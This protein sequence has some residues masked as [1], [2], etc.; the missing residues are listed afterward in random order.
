MSA[1]LEFAPASRTIRSVAKPFRNGVQGRYA[2]Q[3]ATKQGRAFLTAHPEAQVAHVLGA[4]I[5]LLADKLAD[6]STPERERRRIAIRVIR[7][8]RAIEGADGDLASQ[9]R[10]LVVALNTGKQA[11]A[12]LA[13]AGLICARMSLNIDFDPRLVNT[14]DDATIS[15]AIGA[16]SKRTKSRSHD[17]PAINALAVALGC[18]AD[19][20]DTLRKKLIAIVA[21]TKR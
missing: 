8:R 18:G 17:W 16:W 12:N 15:A 5:L 9:R 4:H 21:S 19:D 6:E 11:E 13:G 10:A 2:E 3:A 14:I 1:A 7:A 20:L